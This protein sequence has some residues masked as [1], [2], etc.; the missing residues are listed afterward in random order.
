ML[1]AA[2]GGAW[3]EA[4]PD[5]DGE[6]PAEQPED[7]AVLKVGDSTMLLTEDFGPVVSAD[8]ELAG[9]VAALH[10]LSDIYA[11][12]GEPVA[13]RVLFVAGPDAT[14][15]Q[16]TALLAGVFKTCASE[17]VKVMGGHSI[18]SGE[19][20]AGLSAVGVPGPHGVLTK[21]GRASATAS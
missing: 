20:M 6:S 5:R 18:T 17:G 11:C 10:A 19:W 15:E 14:E 12:G 21:Q 7:C 13:A 2:V 9:R 1:T 3:R 16:M 8:L 4:Y